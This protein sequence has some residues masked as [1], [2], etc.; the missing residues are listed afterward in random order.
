MQFRNPEIL[1]ALFFLIIPII[2]H[3][4][5]LQRF[6]KTPF[7][8]VALLKDIKQQSR[9]S[10]RLK[11]WLILASRLTA[12][13]FLIFAFSGPELSNSERSKF[14][15]ISIIL[16]NSYSMEAKGEK[17]ELLKSTTMELAEYFN[18]ENTDYTLIKM[19]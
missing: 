9:K 15:N 18:S 14:Q 10:E 19:C 5:Q 4:F 2:V 8:N 16:D 11:K 13:T 3:L 1:F 12:L 17:G 6:K 7:T